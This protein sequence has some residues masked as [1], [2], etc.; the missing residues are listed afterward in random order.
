MEYVFT[1]GTQFDYATICEMHL[2]A[3]NQG[4]V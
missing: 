4:V 1:P 3:P 2:T